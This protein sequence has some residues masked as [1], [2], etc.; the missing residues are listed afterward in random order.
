MDVT[1]QLREDYANWDTVLQDNKRI[2]IDLEKEEKLNLQIVERQQERMKQFQREEQLTEEQAKL[3]PEVKAKQTGTCEMDDR[4]YEAFSI[5]KEQQEYAQRWKAGLEKGKNARISYVVTSEGEL[6]TGQSVH[7]KADVTPEDAY[8]EIRWKVDDILGASSEFKPG[9]NRELRMVHAFTLPGRY[10]VSAGFYVNGEFVDQHMG[11]VTINPKPEVAEKSGLTTNNQQPVQSQPTPEK[12]Q[13]VDLPYSKYWVSG[14]KGQEVISGYY[15]NMSG[16][17]IEYQSKKIMDYNPQFPAY[18]L[19]ALAS[20]NGYHV[21]RTLEN[22][23]SVLIV[24]LLG[25]SGSNGKS[26]IPGVRSFGVKIEP[27]FKKARV[28]YVT[29][30][31]KNGELELD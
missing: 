13:I 4:T 14:M 15:F 23:K 6:T 27:D 11:Q 9:Y 26:S 18:G 1:A 10:D 21:Y 17:R 2:L 25:Q 24:T 16:Q 5:K 30:T 12:V 19:F 7:F 8:G 3:S 29:I 31:G 22:N 28:K 20:L